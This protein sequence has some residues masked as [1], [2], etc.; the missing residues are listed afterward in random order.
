VS[1][2]RGP[3]SL[4]STTAELPGRKNSDFGLENRF[5]GRRNPSLSPRGTLYPQNLTLTSPTNGSRSVG[6]VRSLTQATEFNSLFASVIIV[7]KYLDF[8]KVV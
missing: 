2:E 7:S 3:P 6:T 4:V 1:L 8:W 5:Y